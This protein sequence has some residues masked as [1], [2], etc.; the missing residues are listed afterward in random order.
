[1]IFVLV[2][3]EIAAFPH[4]KSRFPSVFKRHSEKF[5][6]EVHKILREKRQHGEDCDNAQIALYEHEH[7]DDCMSI[8]YNEGSDTFFDP[9]RS[10]D[11]VNTYCGSY[12]CGDW[13]PPL[14]DNIT[15]YCGIDVS[16]LTL[17]IKPLG[18]QLADISTFL[19][20]CALSLAF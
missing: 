16:K 5:G 1:M 19:K 20:L 17:Y 18:V 11:F 7:G 9:S 4:P 3:T 6:A 15:K 8:F 13:V 10:R 2:V 12:K 14:M